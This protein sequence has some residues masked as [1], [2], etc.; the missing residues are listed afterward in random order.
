MDTCTMPVKGALSRKSRSA[1][2]KQ[3]WPA[4]GAG[5]G[6]TLPPLPD[7]SHWPVAGFSV[8]FAPQ[9][10]AE[11]H[12]PPTMVAPPSTLQL[13][14]AGSPSTGRQRSEP[15]FCCTCSVPGPHLTWLHAGSTATAQ[16]A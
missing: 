11:T 14:L 8:V 1:P 7:D 13:T 9:V 10:I 16:S 12:S 2:L 5:Q 3:A 4:V 15:S 6:G